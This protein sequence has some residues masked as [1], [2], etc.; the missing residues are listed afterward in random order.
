M[1]ADLA[2][3]VPNTKFE[4]DKAEALVRLGF[5]AVEPVIP[6]ILEW[7][8][9]LNWPVGVV[10]QPFLAGI[11]G[12]LAPY[13]RTVLQGQ[14]DSWKYSLLSVVV[15]QSPALALALRQDLVRVAT[16]P[17]SGEVKEEVDQVAIEILRALN[18]GAAEA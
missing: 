15:D 13:V 18:R 10:F 7:L 12:P 6:Q 1:S 14:D 17:S 2:A 4:T 16:S 3:L 8:Q 9:D 11:G 5:P